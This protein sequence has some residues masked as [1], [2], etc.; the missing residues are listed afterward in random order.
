MNANLLA[1]AMV[2]ALA[3]G[4]YALLDRGAGEALSDAFVE[5]DRPRIAAPTSTPTSGP[6]L[7]PRVTPAPS[8]DAPTPIADDGNRTDCGAIKGTAY[9]SDEERSWYL[10]NCVAT[11]NRADC[12]KIRGTKYLSNTE[13]N[14]Y[15]ATCRR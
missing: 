2:V 10:A 12:D 9:R 1:L 3:L 8:S 5:P 7:P 11:P 6:R 15:L 4:F 14:W 13:R